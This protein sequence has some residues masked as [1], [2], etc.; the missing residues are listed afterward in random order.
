MDDM[1]SEGIEQDEKSYPT[2]LSNKTPIDYIYWKA[3]V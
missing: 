2:K 1:L 3:G